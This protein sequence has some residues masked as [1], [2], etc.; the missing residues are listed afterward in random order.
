MILDHP[1]CLAALYHFIV[2]CEVLLLALNCFLELAGDYFVTLNAQES[3]KLS[4]FTAVT[5]IIYGL[6]FFYQA[7]PN[8]RF[9]SID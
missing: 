8:E 4:K 9:I 3:I 5:E 1:G 2:L 7:H 6:G